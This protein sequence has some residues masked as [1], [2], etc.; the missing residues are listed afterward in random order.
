MSLENDR[1]VPAPQV[2]V[3]GH[4]YVRNLRDDI[5]AGK[6]NDD[7]GLDVV[8]RFLC[9][10]GLRL[11][12]AKILIQQWDHI[13]NVDV[14]I[15]QV[16]GND[17]KNG[18]T[19]TLDVAKGVL[20]LAQFCKGLFGVKF[21]LIGK[22]FYRGSSKWLPT[23]QKVCEYNQKVREAN[24]YMRVNAS[25]Y[26]VVYWRTKGIDILDYGR[27]LKED[28]THLNQVGQVKLYRSIRGAI[29]FATRRLDGSDSKSNAEESCQKVMSAKRNA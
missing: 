4:S 10:G 7:F 3:I 11:P 19:D 14:V 13:H 5:L 8:T 23:A 6:Y 24:E 26:G 20:E 9:R 27:L 2:L 29:M 17:F 21:V 22:L 18:V 1:M 12:Q 25:D 16:G 15:L 28:G